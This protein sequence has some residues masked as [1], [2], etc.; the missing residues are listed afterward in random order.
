[1]HIYIY[2]HTYGHKKEKWTERQD[3]QTGR[4]WERYRQPKKAWLK[5]GALP[6]ARNLNLVPNGASCQRCR[7]H[8]WWAA[9][10]PRASDQVVPMRIQRRDT[11][12]AL[13]VALF[14]PILLDFFMKSL[15]YIDM[16]FCWILIVVDWV[17]EGQWRFKISKI[18]LYQVLVTLCK[19]L[20]LAKCVL[21]ENSKWTDH[22]LL[23]PSHEFAMASWSFTRVSLK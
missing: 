22:N 3:K 9:H 15:T 11:M 21:V 23:C 16:M 2:T 6:N 5:D 13:A 8:R 7:R 20:F 17:S 12:H 10:R 18:G 1:M 4:D 19:L 14:H